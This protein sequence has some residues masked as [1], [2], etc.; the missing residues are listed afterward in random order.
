MLTLEMAAET[1]LGDLQ[2]LQSVQYLQ[3]LDCVQPYFDI[4]FFRQCK[5]NLHQI[6]KLIGP[7]V[8]VIL[9]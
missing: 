9:W 6:I 8:V 2:Y 7:L 3:P 1:I 5:F 4:V